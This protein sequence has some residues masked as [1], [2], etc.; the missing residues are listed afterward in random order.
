LGER[1]SAS[2][3]GA[4]AATATL[5]TACW[6]ISRRASASPNDGYQVIPGPPAAWVVVADEEGGEV[7][8][9]ISHG[10]GGLDVQD[11]A[12]APGGLAAVSVGDG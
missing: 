7:V 2:H 11:P 4:V 5:S 9:I 8:E 10:A 1:I 6:R 12:Q 3:A